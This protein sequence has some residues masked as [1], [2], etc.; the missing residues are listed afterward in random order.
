LLPA[1]F[2]YHRPADVASAVALLQML[3]NGAHPIAGGRSL[4]PM[5]QLRRVSVDHLIDL[6][7]IAELKG[8]AVSGGTVSIGAMTTEH[9]LIASD[10][11]AEAAP[12]V[13]EAT[14]QI[15][16]PEGRHAGTIGGNVASGAPCNDLPGLLQC[17]DASYTLVGPEGSRSIA[18][19]GFYDAAYTTAREDDEL[20]TRIEFA[21]PTGGHA[22]MKQKRQLEDY[23][24]AA[25]A[26]QLDRRGEACARAAIAMTNVGD[27]PVY[28]EAAGA[29]LVGTLCDAQAV[30]SAVAAALTEA[31][32]DKDHRGP[33][34][35]RRHV[36]GVII[37]RAIECAWSRT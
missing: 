21:A 14:L 22:F 12:I 24:T 9:E 36:A 4:I 3:G 8:I 18:A 2:D 32:P 7:D 29:A 17:L 37:G 5:M 6:Q 20:L 16:D 31:E 30:R 35:F 27:V 33:V 34:D 1:E 15:S 26:V 13:R 11:L 25:C 28:S 10:A 19:R 23:A